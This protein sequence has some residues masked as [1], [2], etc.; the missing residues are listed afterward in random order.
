MVLN[1]SGI[2]KFSNILNEIKRTGKIS[3]SNLK[4]YGF[5]NTSISKFNIG[6]FYNYSYFPLITENG[7]SITANPTLI[8]G[9]KYY[10]M[11]TNVYSPNNYF[12]FNNYDLACNLLLVGG[13]GG[14]GASKQI[15]TNYYFG[16]G[17][18]GGDVQTTIRTFTKSINYQ[19]LV[20]MGGFIN[21]GGE[22]SRIFYNINIAIAYGGKSP[23]YSES[24]SVGGISGNNYAGGN[25]SPGS[26]RDGYTY[27]GGG[28]G[29]GA[30]G[31]GSTPP[32]INTEGAGGP[33][34]ETY[35]TGNLVTY[36]AGGVGSIF[37]G[38]YSETS[39]SYYGRGGFGGRANTN[40]LAYGGNG[41]VVI[42]FTLL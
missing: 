6:T 38:N 12:C 4:Y 1:S 16:G 2:L 35:I 27:Y 29:G 40:P 30:G 31:P 18:G 14:G 20:G 15:N 33:G 19:I 17:G 22:N 10:Y 7:V 11:F 13:G 28:G 36:G 37:S 9:K 8:S 5:N 42:Q 34:I 23:N 41:C 21:T 32:D 25:P 26:L 39:S 3:I 24:P